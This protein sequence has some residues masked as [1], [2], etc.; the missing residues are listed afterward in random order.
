MAGR[1]YVTRVEGFAERLIDDAESPKDAAE[2]AAFSHGPDIRVGMNIEVWP[3]DDPQD[4]SHWKVA[5][6]YPGI[7]RPRCEPAEPVVQ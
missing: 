2:S 4:V 6:Y 5:G 1:K 3:G 7:G